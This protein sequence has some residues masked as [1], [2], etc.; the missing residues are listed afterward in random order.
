MRQALWISS[1]ALIAAGLVIAQAPTPLPGQAKGK[2]TKAAPRDPAASPASRPIPQT[3]IAQTYPAAQIKTGESRFS[4]QCG[5]C[6]GRDAAGGETGPDLTRSELVATDDHG[7]KLIALVKSGRPDKGMPA[8]NNL[9][10]AD[11]N[12]IVAFVHSQKTKFETLGGGRRAVD[13]SDLT[14]GKADAGRAYFNGAGKCSTCHSPTGD[15]KGIATRYQGLALLQ[16]LLYPTAGRPAPARPKATVTLASGQTV[17]GPLQ[18][19]DEFSLV[20]TDPAGTR[21]TYDKEAVK[22][23]IDDPMSTHFD[24][25]AKYTDADMHNIFAYLDTLK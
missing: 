16:R 1:A 15:L 25:L 23:K 3:S 20:L 13:P 12:A 19:E 17:T 4:A 24:Q 9:N 10:A 14:T 2:A 18:T 7:D 22:F 11:L 21:Q 6:H 8:F 5:F